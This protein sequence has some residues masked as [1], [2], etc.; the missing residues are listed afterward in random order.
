[1]GKYD[2]EGKKGLQE[3]EVKMDPS[4][5]FS[6]LFGSERFDPWIGELHLAMQT[7]QLVKTME[8]SDLVN[9]NPEELDALGNSASKA[10]KR[11]QL[12]R[13]VHCAC[14]LRDKLDRWVYERSYDGFEEQ[15]RLEA[16]TL[17][18]GQFG[19]ELLVTLGEIYQQRSELYLADELVGRFSLTK[20][21][22][23]IKHST[24]SMGH[25]MQFYQQAASSLWQVKK[26]HD[27]ATKDVS[28]SSQSSQPAEAEAN[29]AAGS[30]AEP[31]SA[32]DKERQ[33]LEKEEKQR[34]AIES[35]LAE[36]LP[37]F[38]Q[39]AWS[40]VVTDIDATITEVT[41]KLLKDKSVA[42]QIRLR[43]AQALQ[44]LGEI[45]VDEGTKAEATQGS[46]TE[47][48]MSS[49]VAKATLQEALM[50]SVREKKAKDQD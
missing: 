35:A 2:R 10:M 50:G 41:R 40:C 25:R 29:G 44:R 38:L 42:W 5:F 49:D 18:E 46:S 17:A 37:M 30:Q 20:R 7:D 24:A 9:E 4:M 6:L 14:H 39:T 19:P 36:A 22:A 11:K 26:M 31:D 33:E 16:S 43:R 1:M 23:S 34:E 32:E 12:R 45:F 47:K 15:M 28:A 27:V 48:L 8:K 21:V 3:G 13:E